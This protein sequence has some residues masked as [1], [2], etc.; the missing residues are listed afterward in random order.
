MKASIILTHSATAKQ[1]DDLRA[2]FEPGHF[3]WWHWFPQAWLLTDQKDHSVYQLRDMIT[4][5]CPGLTVYIFEIEHGSRYAGFAP[6][7]WEDW[8]KTQWAKPRH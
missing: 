3:G 1:Q 8:L 6:P 4:N 2:L 7:D 5:A